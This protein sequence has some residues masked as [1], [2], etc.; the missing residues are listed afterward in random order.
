MTSKKLVLLNF[1]LFLLLAQAAGAVEYGGIGGRPAYPRPDNQRTESIFI[2]SI[3]LGETK[4][5]GIKVLNNTGEEKTINLYAVDSVVSSG[6][7][8]S[9]AQLG[10]AQSDVGNWIKLTKTEV[11]LKPSTNEVVDFSITAPANADVGEHNGC[12]ILQEKKK[13][14]AQGSGIAINFR[15]GLR[16]ALMVPGDI[17]KNLEI[18]EMKVLKDATKITY[19][20]S[21]KN[22]GNV[23]I[24]A[25]IKILTTNL[26]GQVIVEHGGGYPI[27][28]G[29]RS[30]WNF[31]L[32]NPYWGGWFKS[33]MFVSYDIDVKTEIGKS[34]GNIKTL[35]G[36]AVWFFVMPAPLALLVELAILVLLFTLLIYVFVRLNRLRVIKKT[37]QLTSVSENDDILSLAKKYDVD[38]KLIAKI[39]KL[40]AP[41]TI[42]TGQKLKLPPN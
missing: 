24:D 4:K 32:A 34:S 20:P 27:L 31:E 30:D 19:S 23:S 16:V 39:N 25:T 26:F 17:K 33:S 35:A 3:E 7:A 29:Q 40:E 42:K 28:R 38:W 13:S 6:G 10:D 14:A 5:E 18:V 9:C 37:W 41:Y 2:H 8:F 11:T 15:T 21:V 1:S 22:T 12:I 36:P